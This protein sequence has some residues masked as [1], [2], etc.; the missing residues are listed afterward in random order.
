MTS[1]SS[2]KVA[3]SSSS[4][5]RRFDGFQRYAVSLQYHG[6]S[7]LGFSY[8]HAQEDSLARGV[9]LRGYR[10]VEG[11]LK[12]AFHDLF[13]LENRGWENIQVSSRTDRGGKFLKSFQKN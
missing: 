3:K 6:G 2:T 12:Q 4:V 9:D 1:I 8:Q 7:F 13:G 5:V 10:S 11:R